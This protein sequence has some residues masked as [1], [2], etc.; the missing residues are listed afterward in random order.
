VVRLVGRRQG[1]GDDLNAGV[2]MWAVW[3]GG[4]DSVT[5][6]ASVAAGGG[7]LRAAAAAF[8]AVVDAEDE[9]DD[10]DAAAHAAA[11]GRAHY[12]GLALPYGVVSAGGARRTAAYRWGEGGCGCGGEGGCDKGVV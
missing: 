6:C 3:L 8:D 2:S 12:A 4:G 10:A 7:V 5:S 9:G 11:H 1:G